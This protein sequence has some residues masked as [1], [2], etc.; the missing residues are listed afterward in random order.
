M[1]YLS[2]CGRGRHNGAGEGYLKADPV[3]KRFQKKL[4]INQTDAESRV[5]HYLKSRRFQKWKFRRQHGI[6]DYIMD[7]LCL[8]G[9][10]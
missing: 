6:Q 10:S 5:W 7:F 3:L 1:H 9:N 4:R 2:P 8:T